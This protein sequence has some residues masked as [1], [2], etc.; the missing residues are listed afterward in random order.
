VE[1]I[2]KD[3]KGAGKKIGIIC[4]ETSGDLY[5]G[6][7]AESLHKILPE[8]ELIGFGGALLA[9]SGVRLLLPYAGHGEFGFTNV[10]RK[11][12][13]YRRH[14]Q[15]GAALLLRESPD[16]LLFIDNPGFNLSLAKKV[17][18]I[19]SIYYIPPK[20]WAH[21]YRRIYTIKRF[22]N[23]VVPIFS[24]EQSLYEQEGIESRWFGH[25]VLDLVA[26]EEASVNLFS[27][28]GLDPN[29]PVAALFP[30]SRRS[31]VSHILP[32]LLESA[33]FLLSRNPEIQWVVSVASPWLKESILSQTSS[34]RKKI[35]VWEGSSYELARRSLFAL[36]ASGT[37]NLELAL[38]R[39]PMVVYYRMDALSYA[40][41][42]RIVK[43]PFA[44]PV[45]IIAGKEVVSEHI[46]NISL[47]TL[48]NDLISLLT[49]EE[50]RRQRQAFGEIEEALRGDAFS[51]QE[52]ISDRIASWIATR[53]F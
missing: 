44:S 29:M 43:I 2:K 22:F 15:R 42:K 52:K 12:P 48:R 40:I 14:L 36:C 39:C 27:R 31:E 30:G 6:M 17:Q 8:T 21:G 3:K 35:T 24:F 53:F 28:T 23:A 46:Q 50:R 7:L 25:P 33:D 47:Q 20:I 49:E 18:T 16:L 51:K 34:F 5:A 13:A 41:T 38:F 1:E 26:R 32:L 11:L 37:L 10:I 9:S 45:N 19:P 4:G